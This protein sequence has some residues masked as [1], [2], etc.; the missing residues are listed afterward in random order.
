MSKD[1]NPCTSLSV[2]DRYTQHHS[3]E[4]NRLTE[5]VDSKIKEWPKMLYYYKIMDFH[6]GNRTHHQLGTV[7]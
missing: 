2:K 5:D 4:A 6:P 7:G 1:G 3:D